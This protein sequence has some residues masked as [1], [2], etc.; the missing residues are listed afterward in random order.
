MLKLVDIYPTTDK[1]KSSTD[2]KNIH[3]NMHYFINEARQQAK[4]AQKYFISDAIQEFNDK[5]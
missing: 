5:F 4:R 3:K 1:Y 2:D